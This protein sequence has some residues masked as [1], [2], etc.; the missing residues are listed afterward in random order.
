MKETVL[1][2]VAAAVLTIGAARADDIADCETALAAND[3]IAAKMFAQTI[4]VFPPAATEADRRRA[5]ACLSQSF[6][7]P[8][9]YDA[10]RDA[11]RQGDAAAAGR[12]RAEAMVAE[13]GAQIE[14]Q[15]ENRRRAAVAQEIAEMAAQACVRLYER[16]QDAALTSQV[17][18]GAFMESGLPN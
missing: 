8:Y 16:D 5:L 17:C 1:I 13:L 12:A 2:L 3:M 15:E 18:L 4:L 7:T 14:V 11:Y 10:G 6:D 9:H